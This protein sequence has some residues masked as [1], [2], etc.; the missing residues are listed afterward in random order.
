MRHAVILAGGSGTRLWPASRRRRPKQLLPLG[1][2]D[3][4]LLALA[5]ARGLRV[6][7]DVLAVTNELF[8]DETRAFAPVLAE[9]IGRN[10]AA[11]IAWAAAHLLERDPDAVLA[12]LPA[13][14]AVT[15][16]D[17][18]ATVLATALDAAERDD[19]IATVGIAP[20]RAETGFGYLEVDAA[21]LGQVVPVARFVEKPDRATAER[22][23]A[24]GRYLWNAGIFC[25]SARRLLA[26]L[27]AHVPAIA[28][29]ARAIVAGTEPVREAYA[30][31]PS[32]SIDHAVM[33]RAARVVTVPAAVGWDDVG[34]WAALPAVRG[35]DADGNTLV[36][37]AYVVDGANNVVVT[38]GGV[39][40]TVGV[41]DLVVVRDGDAVLVIPRAA[42]QDV[43]KAVDLLS[44]K[45]LD[46][47]L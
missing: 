40:I 10:T 23:L 26:E 39:V 27:E 17:G 19:V 21:P 8:A 25:A 35:A 16:E 2:G 29:T 47:Y 42:A 11:A 43:R 4:P 33:E 44:E 34:S 31:L 37:G 22:Y 6:C 38:D 7:A 18:L 15:D 45:K 14:Q 41:S 32:I 1:P 30:K 13:D 28:R 12:V 3:E 24:S 36:N 46:R 20:T 9:P 5:V